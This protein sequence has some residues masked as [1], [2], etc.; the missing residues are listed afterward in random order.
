MHNYSHKILLACW[1][2][3]CVTWMS[4]SKQDEWLD[5]KANK[6]DIVPSKLSDY[7]SLLDYDDVYLNNAYPSLGQLSCDD[8]YSSY[9]NWQSSVVLYRNAYTWESD[10]FAGTNSSDWNNPYIQ[11]AYANICL[12]GLKKIDRV[13]E[14][15]SAWDNVKGSALFYRGQAYFHLLQHFAR[16]YDITT[17]YTDPG[18]VLRN[19]S[20]VNQLFPRSSVEDSYNQVIADLQ[21]AE[22]L[23]PSVPSMLTRPSVRATDALLS[24][25]YLSMRD[26]TKAGTYADK[27]LQQISTLIDYNTL[28]SA[29][30]YPLPSFQAGNKEVIF[31]ATAAAS[32]I[33]STNGF[34]DSNLYKSYAAND[35]RKTIFFKQGTGTVSFRGNY[36]GVS[37]PF[38][39]MAINECY[40][41][42]AESAARKGNIAAAMNDLNSL[43]IKRW[44]TGTYVPLTALNADDALSKVLTERRKELLYTGILRW[45]D[46]RRLNKEP[47]YAKTLLRNLNGQVYT[48]KPDDPK[49]VFP[50]P[51]NEI[52]L[53]GIAQ[54][55]R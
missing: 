20:D 30:T 44:K 45:I 29:S 26:Y 53:S 23:L 11:V 9:Q 35:L 25:V 13:S 51:D 4:C 43:L 49:Y 24:R 6:R 14:N 8:Y 42:R 7:Q 47:A 55:P 34:V 27:V 15:Q 52:R 41:V 54:N 21:E 3:S 1:F 36:T 48:L 28:N 39:G 38:G 50:I 32:T 33:Q 46:L 2:T 10:I 31:Y 12:E 18:I 22:T 17:A 16:P 19:T 5:S 37:T 40:L